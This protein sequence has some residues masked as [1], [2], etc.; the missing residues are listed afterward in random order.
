MNGKRVPPI[1]VLVLMLG[2]SSCAP[3]R[4]TTSDQKLA[5][6]G[7][8]A[9]A[10]PEQKSFLYIDVPAADSGVSNLM[11]RAFIGDAT[12]MKQLTS[13]MARGASESTYVVVGSRSSGVAY[14]AVKSALEGFTGKRLP[15]LH[16]GLIGDSSQAEKL[17]P[18]VDALGSEYRVLPSPR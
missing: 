13:V 18:M 17:R 3:I 9:T 12:F 15:Y 6:T 11:M 16:L 8:A 14:S 10:F 7:L 4:Q 2:L 5:R 1:I